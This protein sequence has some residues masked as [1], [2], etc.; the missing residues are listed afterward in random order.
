LIAVSGRV[1]TKQ[2]AEFLMSIIWRTAVALS[3]VICHYFFYSVSFQFYWRKFMKNYQATFT[4]VLLCLFLLFGAALSVQAGF[5]YVLNDATAGNNIYGFA[6]NE[7]T[8]ELTPL[9]GFPVGTGFNGGGSTNLEMIAVDN[10]NKRLYAVNRGSNNISAYSI[11]ETTGA[12]TPL[13]FSPIAGI[14]NE[15]SIK[16][17]PTGSPLIVAGDAV[18]S[19]VITSNSATPAAGS[20]FAVGTGVGP[21]GSTLSRDG[22]YFY[23]GGNTGTFF[24]GFSVAAASG[25]LTA[26]A[27]SPFDTG[28]AT[29]YP[30]A[31]DATGRLFVV[32]SRLATTRVYTTSN[33]IPT[34]VTGSPFANGLTGI[35]AEGEIHPNG[36]FFYLA[37][38]S[39][40]RI[41]VYRIN[42]S[43]ADTTLTAITGS[44]YQTG[45][46][47]SLSL[48]FNRGGNF[49]FTANGSSRNLTSFSVDPATGALSNPMVLAANSAGGAGTLNGI[50]YANFASAAV[51]VSGRVLTSS[52]RAISKATVTVSNAGGVIATAKT[53]SF[54]YFRFESLPTGAAYTFAVVA[55]GFAF[56]PQ[57]VTPTADLTDFDL[58]AQP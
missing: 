53:S 31:S 23:T 15:R 10:L 17:H 9:A 2:K 21:G 29:P 26:L 8:G 54:G 57:T 28:G 49:L 43:G 50:A 30:T 36:N 34:A 42:G 55:K 39:N 22:N 4:C 13:P 32:P 19:Y 18:A 27:G 48:V 6:V 7:Q 20:P 52:G 37:D 35:T 33:G 25:V 12:L 44:P 16:V 14:A 45:G 38:R 1:P 24:A 58:T 56:S 51:S 11:N 40:S 46:T 5:V 47:L 41:G 3:D